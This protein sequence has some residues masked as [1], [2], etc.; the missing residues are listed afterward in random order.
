MS[1][2]TKILITSLQIFDQFAIRPKEKNTPLE[3]IRKLLI[4]LMWLIMSPLLVILLPAKFLFYALCNL[5]TISGSRYRNGQIQ[6]AEDHYIHPAT[7]RK[8][9]L[10]GTLHHA[11]K[12]FY[13]DICKNI[14]SYRKNG[15]AILSEGVVPLSKSQLKKVSRKIEV[16]ARSMTNHLCDH[17]AL[18]LLFDLSFQHLEF[19]SIPSKNIDMDVSA[20]LKTF[21]K[22]GYH[23]PRFEH[24]DRIS[25][26]ESLGDAL[27]KMNE[28]KFIYKQI[29]EM[30]GNLAIHEIFAKFSKSGREYNEVILK[31]RDQN[32]VNQI[33]MTGLT[34]DVLSLWGAAHLKGMGALLEKQGYNR[35]SRTWNVALDIHTLKLNPALREYIDVEKTHEFMNVF[36]SY[37]MSS[38]MS[39]GK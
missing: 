19:C 25:F 8:I 4:M 2:L 9:V 37:I 27:L 28:G 20:I 1:F 29:N 12:K 36:G 11:E 33:Q 13:Q 7:G 15:F 35:V 32:A 38:S 18:S 34:Q 10:I 23:L 26:Y 5:L 14:Q 39:R 22:N 6:M 21:Q 3:M 16:V 24:I 30:A 17:S 31:L